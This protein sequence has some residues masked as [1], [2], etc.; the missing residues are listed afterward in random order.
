[1]I[2]PNPNNASIAVTGA[3]ALSSGGAFTII[4][5]DARLVNQNGNVGT[6]PFEVARLRLT[7]QAFLSL[8]QAMADA[9]KAHENAFGPLPALADINKAYGDA[10]AVNAEWSSA[11]PP[12][13]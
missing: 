10:N 2:V 9:R 6:M 11:P 7:P 3:T 12:A 8:E 13:S 5:A 4:C 1:M